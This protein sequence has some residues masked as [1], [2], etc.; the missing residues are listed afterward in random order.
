VVRKWLHVIVCN[1][2]D[3]GWISESEGA[4]LKYGNGSIRCCQHSG[5]EE[6]GLSVQ[7]Q[8]FDFDFVRPI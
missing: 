6:I 4:H 8:T 3:S 7:P 2:R 1:F 5:D